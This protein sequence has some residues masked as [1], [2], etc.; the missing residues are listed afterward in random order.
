[1]ENWQRYP[2]NRKMSHRDVIE[3]QDHPF[4]HVFYH[5]PFQEMSTNS[6]RLP[7]GHGHVNVSP[8][9]TQL[10]GY[11][12]LGGKEFKSLFHFIYLET[13]LLGIEP[14]KS[15]LAQRPYDTGYPASGD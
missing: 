13:T 10:E 5:A 9:R 4:S 7:V 11:G 15:N 8:E 3:F 2:I 12:P 1:M 6:I 14:G